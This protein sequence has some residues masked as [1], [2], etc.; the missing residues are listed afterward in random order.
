MHRPVIFAVCA[1]VLFGIGCNGMQSSQ[2]AEG[3][4]PVQ[5]TDLEPGEGKAV[6][7]GYLVM[8]EYSGRV[9]GKEDPFDSNTAKD[10]DGNGTK[11]PLATYVGGGSMIPGFDEALVGMKKGMV[12][13]VTIPWQKGYGENGNPDAGIAPKSDLEFTIKLLD[14]VHPDEE[15]V[16]WADDLTVGTGREVQETDRVTIHY[17]GTY[18]N[19][20]MFDDSHLR[21]DAEKGGTPYSF[22]VGRS[23]AIPGVDDGIRGMRVGGKRR[24]K[25][26]P[27]LV[28]GSQGYSSIMGNQI[29]II[30]IELLAAEPTQ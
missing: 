11:A 9:V 14:F 7:N 28:F 19:G 22:V 26:P 29:V 5:K 25:L 12:R 17:R 3:G 24:L 1:L 4:G 15:A 27:A 30:E 6:E 13:K 21:G 16:Y 2:G 20:M 18:V 23:E 10:A 8:L